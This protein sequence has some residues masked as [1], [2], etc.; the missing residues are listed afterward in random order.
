MT[1]PQTVTYWMPTARCPEVQ[2]TGWDG[3]GRG[4]LCS[5]LTSAWLLCLDCFESEGAV[6]P[7]LL[8]PHSGFHPAR[9]SE[10][11]IVQM[12][13]GWGVRGAGRCLVASGEQVPPLPHAG[14]GGRRQ[15][16]AEPAPGRHVSLLLSPRGSA[17]PSRKA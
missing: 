15:G 14:R 3:G 10:P 1:V 12:C 8:N 17:C 4:C 16:Q 7:S 5:V 11:C 9:V 2:E 6:F 13:V